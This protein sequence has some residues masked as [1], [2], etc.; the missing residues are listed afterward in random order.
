LILIV[1]GVYAVV[2]LA[3]S[4]RIWH[5]SDIIQNANIS[6]DPTPSDGAVSPQPWR[7]PD[8]LTD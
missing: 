3:W 7:P 2:I 1:V 8:L 4:A 6:C 5:A